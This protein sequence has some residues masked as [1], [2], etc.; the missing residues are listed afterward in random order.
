M[1]VT[2]ADLKAALGI[3]PTDAS[4]DASVNKALATALALV[5]AYVGFDMSDTDTE[6]EYEYSP[7]YRDR[8]NPGWTSRNFIHLPVWPVI[9]IIDIQDNDGNSLDPES[10]RLIKGPGR[11]EFYSGLPSYDYMSLHFYA[12][13]DPLPDDLDLVV[14]NLA[15][16][17][18]NNGG[19]LQTAANPLKSL[20]MFDA[21]SMS[22][23]TTGSAGTDGALEAWKFVLDKYRVNTG[24]VLK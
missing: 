1:A 23:D 5:W 7:E 20:T 9:E 22:F 6:R 13:Y 14:M 21:M 11:V 17:V 18:Y 10:Y 3:A 8:V 16:T 2:K 12:G 15:S 4:K 24:P 19:S